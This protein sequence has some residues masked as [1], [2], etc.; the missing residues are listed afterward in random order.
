MPIAS[1][2]LKVAKWWLFKFQESSAIA[3]RHRLLGHVS[4]KLPFCVDYILERNLTEYTK[5]TSVLLT[6]SDIFMQ[7][8]I[9]QRQIDN[10]F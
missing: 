2:D 9:S 10:D 8:L 5:V 4:L 7:K 3:H 1:F 6:F